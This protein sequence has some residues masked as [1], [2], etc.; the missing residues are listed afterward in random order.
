MSIHPRSIHRLLLS[1]VSLC[2]MTLISISCFSALFFLPR[3]RSSSPRPSPQT[4]VAAKF[5]DDAFASN[6]W[7]SKVGGV[8]MEEINRLEMAVLNM[9]EWRL[10]VRQDEYDAA[11]RQLEAC[12]VEVQAK[13]ASLEGAVGVVTAS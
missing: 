13:D 6:A 2:H 7:Y 3:D 8:V 11:M 10:L 1:T 12:W 5:H 9:T 4:L